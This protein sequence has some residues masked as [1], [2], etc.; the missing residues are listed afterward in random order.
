MYRPKLLR[1]EALNL[2]SYL[3]EIDRYSLLLR[4]DAGFMDIIKKKGP[5]DYRDQRSVQGM[6]R[7]TFYSRND[8]LS[9][10]LYMINSGRKLRN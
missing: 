10:R 3:A 6:L 7:N 1:Q 4:H 5:L 9:Y 8:I 2:D